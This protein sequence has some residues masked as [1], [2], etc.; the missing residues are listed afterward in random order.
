MFV[1]YEKYAV[2]IGEGVSTPNAGSSGYGSERDDQRLWEAWENS[3]KRR[4]YRSSDFEPEF[5][6]RDE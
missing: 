1:G 3:S 2:G 6:I 4:P 5:F